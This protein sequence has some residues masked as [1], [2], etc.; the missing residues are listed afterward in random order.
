[1]ELRGAEPPGRLKPIAW[2]DTTPDAQAD[3]ALQRLTELVTRFEDEAQ[4][5]YS[6]VTPMFI[7]RGGGDYDHLA[8]VKEWSIASDGEEESG[9]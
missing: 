8:R 3:R 5:Y 6:R 9:E 1:V 7:R 2:E 4:P